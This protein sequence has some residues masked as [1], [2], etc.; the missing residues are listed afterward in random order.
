MDLRDHDRASLAW[1][2]AHS[3][4]RPTR[5]SRDQLLAFP[6]PSHTRTLRSEVRLSSA[7]THRVHLLPSQCP[8][9]TLRCSLY[10]PSSSNMGA[11][12][13]RVHKANRERPFQSPYRMV[14]SDRCGVGATC[15][16]RCP[17]RRRTTMYG[18]RQGPLLHYRT[19]RMVS[20]V[21]RF[22]TRYSPLAQRSG[23]CYDGHPVFGPELSQNSGGEA[24]HPI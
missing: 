17:V 4:V 23:C 8:S 18:T 2:R 6:R 19:V 1:Q 15:V 16:L 7:I 3:S 24:R 14:G 5:L 11:A 21:L 20:T 13:R 9:Q 12:K 10:V 22:R